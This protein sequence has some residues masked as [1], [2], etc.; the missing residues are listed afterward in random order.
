MMMKC[1][2]FQN[3]I[4]S[5]LEH[6]DLNE[7]LIFENLLYFLLKLFQITKDEES[8][9]NFYIIFKQYIYPIFT[10]IS[11]LD[12]D[13]SNSSKIFDLALQCFSI[14]FFQTQ[15]ELNDIIQPIEFSNY[16]ISNCN[17][18]KLVSRCSLFYRQCYE[19][20]KIA[21]FVES[22]KNE[23]LDLHINNI[24]RFIQKEDDYVAYDFL[25]TIHIYGVKPECFEIFLASALLTQEN[26]NDFHSNPL[27][28]IHLFTQDHAIKVQED[29][30]LL[31]LIHY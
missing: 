16:V 28:F 3:I 15:A 8:L 25:R 27:C 22:I 2:F 23:I 1:V 13:E 18:T 10:E 26:I 30:L 12:N 14:L 6:F 4:S 29:L 9:F 17:D 19:S 24:D 20:K 11:I 21:N 31:Q 7:R 5:L